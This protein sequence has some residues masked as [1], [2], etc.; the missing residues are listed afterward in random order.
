MVH[1]TFSPKKSHS[2]L[3]NYW[4]IV[5]KPECKIKEVVDLSGP[6]VHFADNSKASIMAL[7]SPALYRLLTI[8]EGN[9][10]QNVTIGK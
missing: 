8:S 3:A 10:E 6:E 9:K 5:S 7:T 1:A 4:S 2:L